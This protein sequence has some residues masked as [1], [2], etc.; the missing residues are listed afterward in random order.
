MDLIVQVIYFSILE[1]I[2]QTL[3]KY[4]IDR[5]SIG[6]LSLNHLDRIE[7]NLL[8]DFQFKTF[9]DMG[10]GRFIKFLLNDPSTKKVNLTKPPSFYSSTCL[11][12]NLLV[13]LFVSSTEN[14]M[15]MQ[16]EKG[17]GVDIQTLRH[18]IC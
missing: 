11:C 3:R 4:L 16:T 7:A 12:K 10:Y 14:V 13:N 2:L 6:T 1:K 9:S 15:L 5:I 17:G 18:I 8:E